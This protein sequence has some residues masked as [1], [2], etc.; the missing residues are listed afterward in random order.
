MADLVEIA[1][2]HLKVSVSAQGAETQSLQ[3]IAG[4]EFLWHGDPAWWSGR[5]PV[6]FPIVGETPD[7]KIAYGDEQRDLPRHGFARRSA[8]SLTKHSDHQ[9]TYRLEDNDDTRAVYPFSFALDITHALEGRTLRVSATVWNR[10]TRNMPFG[11]GFHPAFRWPIPGAEGLQHRIVLEN[12][13][14]PTLAQIDESGLLKAASLPS[15]FSEGVLDLDPALFEHDA[16]IFPS[17]AGAALRFEA[18]T[19]PSLRFAF[20]NLPNLALWQKP[21]A[22][23]LCIEPWHGMAARAGAGPQIT[24]RPGTIMLEPGQSVSF[25]FSVTL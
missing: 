4:Q 13:A 17:G 9:C 24:D 19:G 23:F 20:E 6:L 14:E 11:F 8:F 15:L 18:D 7:G 21:D 22:P 5:A 10:D 12:G 2:E 16:L 1:N 3:T 25:A